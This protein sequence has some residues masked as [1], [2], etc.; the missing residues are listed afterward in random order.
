MR[1]IA[2]VLGMFTVSVSMAPHPVRACGDSEAPSSC[3]DGGGEAGAKWMLQ[4]VAGAL[5]ADKQ[6]ALRQFARGEAG[7]RT[8]DTYVFCV[9]PDGIMTA[10]P[11]PSLLGRN[12][13]DLHDQTGNYFIRTMMGTARPGT[14]SHIKYLFPRP[15]GTMALP[16]TTFYTRVDDQVCGVGVYEGE[17]VPPPTVSLQEQ[18][19]QL[20]HRLDGELPSTAHADW[21]AF[22]QALKERDTMRDAVLAKARENVE[23][24]QLALAAETPGR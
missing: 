19:A 5:K 12:V 22:L 15:G 23:A 16:K 13:A 11:S 17:D 3:D 24:A 21:E 6:R 2:F 4:R 18:V 8:M 7:F 20:Q 9:G 14:V 1:K 10:H